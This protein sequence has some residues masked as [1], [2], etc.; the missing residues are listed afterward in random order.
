M[1]K[2]LE[3]YTGCLL[4]PLFELP[5]IGEWLSDLLSK[6]KRKKSFTDFETKRKREATKIKPDTTKKPSRKK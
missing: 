1:R 5:G 4:L 2:K 6:K 3:D